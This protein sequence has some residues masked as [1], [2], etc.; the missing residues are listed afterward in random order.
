[1]NSGQGICCTELAWLT[2]SCHWEM[3]CVHD[4]SSQSQ[5]KE[6]QAVLP[7]AFAGGTRGSS[8]GHRQSAFV[9]FVVYGMACFVLRYSMRAHLHACTHAPWPLAWEGPRLLFAP[10]A[11]VGSP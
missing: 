11:L 6:H 7:T 1:M 5:T 8:K 3:H 10:S 2:A 4:S 9:V